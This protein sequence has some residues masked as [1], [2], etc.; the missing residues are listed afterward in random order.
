M[1]S[2]GKRE[3]E[4][5]GEYCALKI[6]SW[7]EECRKFLNTGEKK[8]K[9]SHL[10]HSEWTWSCQPILD[11]WPEEFKINLCSFIPVKFAV[12][13]Y[14]SKR[15]LIHQPYVPSEDSAVQADALY[16]NMWEHSFRKP[17]NPLVHKAEKSGAIQDPPCP[18]TVIILKASLWNRQHSKK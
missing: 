14:S 6:G 13:C 9:K 12:I 11:F 17:K 3:R 10:K 15:K 8:K 18:P 7:A 4:R 1:T 5:C 2:A 16:W